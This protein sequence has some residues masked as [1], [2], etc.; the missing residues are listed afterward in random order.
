MKRTRNTQF[1]YALFALLFL[2]NSGSSV[3]SQVKLA[4]SGAQFL[5]VESDAKAGGMDDWQLRL[6]Q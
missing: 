4:Q 6:A 1:I 2:L 5:S 3:F